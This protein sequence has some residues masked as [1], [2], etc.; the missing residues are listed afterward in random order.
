MFAQIRI[1]LIWRERK[2]NALTQAKTLQERESRERYERAAALATAEV[3][4]NEAI[5]AVQG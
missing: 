4:M 1:I 3:E 5:L 2:I